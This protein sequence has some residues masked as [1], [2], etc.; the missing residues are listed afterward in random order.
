ML[1]RLW[2]LLA[3][4]VYRG[5][6]TMPSN[7][8]SQKPSHKRTFQLLAAFATLFLIALAVGCT[9]F[10]VNPTL[11][12]ITVGPTATILQGKTVQMT[13]TG[14]F[15]D[16]T[17]KTLTSGVFWSS[18]AQN[19]A[20]V[21]STSGL[22]MGVSPGQ[23]TISGAQGA[24]TAG[25]AVI[26]VTIAGLTAIT[27]TPTNTTIHVGNGQNFVATGTTTSGPVVITD[28][29]TWTT[30][31]SNVTGVT[32]GSNTGILTTDNTV[33]NGTTTITVIATDPIS[34]ISGNTKLTILNP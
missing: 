26:T 18:D 10:F 21:G 28:S 5:F 19:I 9:G 27:V 22:V 34:G 15:N 8:L 1:R 31:P 23:A 11:T 33:A 14:T 30:N 17:T 2:T 16:G 24:V 6:L 12:T 4:R 7:E 25:T 32:L 3:R 20:T 13:A 29:V